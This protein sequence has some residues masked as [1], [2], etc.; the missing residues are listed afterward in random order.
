MRAKVRDV[1][2]IAAKV[3]DGLTLGVEHL[4]VASTMS[5]R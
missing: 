5:Q 4:N 3:K 1:V 2:S